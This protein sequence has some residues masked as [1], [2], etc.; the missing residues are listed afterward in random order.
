MLSLSRKI[1]QL[2][3]TVKA[4]K[5]IRWELIGTEL[6]GKTLGLVGLGR[7]GTYLA[8]IGKGFGMK[9]LVY[10]PYVPPEKI[11][12][13]GGEPVKLDIVLTRS[14]Y[15]VICCLLTDET[16]GLINDK[17]IAKM[18]PTSYLVNV[19]RGPIVNEKSLIQALQEK[20]I[21]GAGLDVFEKEPPEPN[22]ALL[23]L[24][25]I[26]TS[27]H[28]AGLSVESTERIQLVVA[29][30]AARML[31]GEEPKFLVNKELSHAK[32]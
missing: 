12:E 1:P 25:N 26:V 32:C 8:T 21:A 5:W 11:T 9:L 23:K 20:R 7:V 31:K 18:K 28:M 10:D 27:S 3:A 4:G 17:A 6:W 15:I 29:E 30:E 24:D 13:V 19:A 22:N 2:N 14:D 16:R